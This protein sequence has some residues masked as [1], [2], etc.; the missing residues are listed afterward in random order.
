[1]Y[2]KL[3]G[4]GAAD[5]DRSR[6]GESAVRGSTSSLLDGMELRRD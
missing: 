5:C 1:L 4:T 3:L 6:F 2:L